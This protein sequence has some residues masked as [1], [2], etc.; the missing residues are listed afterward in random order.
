MALNEFEQKMYNRISSAV[1]GSQR[2]VTYYN[3]EE[4]G[5]K[6]LDILVAEDSPTQNL[7]TVAANSGSG[8]P[9]ACQL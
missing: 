6:K 3:S 7:A 2:V 5:D 8:I 9:P 1:G 4:N